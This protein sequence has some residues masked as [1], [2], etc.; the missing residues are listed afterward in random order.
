MNR[1]LLIAFIL[2]YGISFSQDG[3]DKKFQAGIGFSTGL[4][5]NKTD[6]KRMDVNGVGSS[7]SIG[8][9]FNYNLSSTIAFATGIDIDFETN[10]I[11]P[12]ALI[13]NSYYRYNDTKIELQEDS[14]STFPGYN[15]TERKQKPVYLTVPTMLLFRTKYFGDLRYF[16]KFGLR[17]SLLMGNKIND[18]G[19]NINPTTGASEA[20]EN[21]SMK[22]S[23]DM[24]FIRS[25]VG[26]ALGTEWNFSGST[27]LCFELGYYYG[28]T[29]IYS[30]NKGDKM[31]LYYAD[32]TNSG[33]ATYY[34]NDMMQNQLQLKIAVLF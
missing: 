21:N 1:N 9:T 7:V 12:S 19:F 8:L 18:K 29:G 33:L 10:K 25:N 3:M 4:N 26:L 2:S 28:F 30:N 23:R 5:L 16:A 14:K 32:S 24:S 27:S 13:G 11:K 15:W 34:S 20:I 31:S 22:A 17:T 6:T